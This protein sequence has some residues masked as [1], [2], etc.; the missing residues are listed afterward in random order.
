MF[1]RD[2][3]HVLNRLEHSQA[4]VYL[5]FWEEVANIFFPDV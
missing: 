5:V 2:I 4:N 1:E 3:Y